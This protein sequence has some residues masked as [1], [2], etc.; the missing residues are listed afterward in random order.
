MEFTIFKAAMLISNALGFIA[1]LIRFTL[2]RP[3]PPGSALVYC[4]LLLVLS[5]FYAMDARR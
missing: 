4:G 2:D 5:I 3:T 1:A